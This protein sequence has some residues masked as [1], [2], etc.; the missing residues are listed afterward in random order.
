MPKEGA[1]SRVFSE[2]KRRISRKDAAAFFI[3]LLAV[4][5]VHFYAFTNKLINHDDLCEMFGGVSF[6]PSGRWL[7]NPIIKLTGRISAPMLNGLVGS[8]FL[9]LTILTVAR[10]LGVRGDDHR[11]PPAA[12]AG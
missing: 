10:V 3:C 9:A 6:L 8:I 11:R 4:L 5:A 7:L 12:P 1:L 2:I